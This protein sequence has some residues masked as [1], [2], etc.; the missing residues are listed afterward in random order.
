[1]ASYLPGNGSGYGV[2]GNGGYG[3][4]GGRERGARRKRLAAVAGRVYS[5]GAS[6][7]SE[8][9]ESYNQTRS[10]QIDTPESIKMTIPGSF[11]D[12]AIVTRGNEQMVLF[13]SYAKRHVKNSQRQYANPGGPPHPASMDMNEQEYWSQEW[14]RHEDE[15]AIVDV[16][17]RGWIY[18]PHK[19]P[20]TRRNRV[21]I[22]LARQLSGIP[23]PRA[24]QQDPEPSLG[25]IHRQHEEEREHMRITK[26]AKEIERR[27]QAEKEAAQVGG[28]SEAPKQ[29][30]SEEEGDDR[31]LYP[32]SG[33]VTSTL[34]SAPGSPTP[35]IGR[36]STV[37]GELSDAELAVA[38]ANLMARLGPFLTTPLV[39][40]SV[41]FFFYNDTQSQSRT[42]ETNDS[43]HFIMRAALDFVPTHV[44]VLANEDLSVTEPVQIIEPK[45]VSLISDIDDTIKHSN[46]S[47]GAKEIFRNTF[48]R[49]L[50][51]L[52]VDGVQE[53]PW[54]LFPVIASY[55]KLAG[56]PPGSIHLK[57]YSGMLQG[58]FEPVAERKKGTL[59]KIMMDFPDRKFLLVGD[60]GEADLEVYTEIAVSNPGRIIAIFI[61]DVT[62]PEQ[63]GYF[64][65][66]F[67][68]GNGRNKGKAPSV[69]IDQRSRGGSGD[70][71]SSRSA[72]PARML[73]EPPEADNTA[74]GDLINL[75]EEPE[76]ISP[77]DPRALSASNHNQPIRKPPPPRPAKP[78][79]LKS[80]PAIPTGKSLESGN[81]TD[82]K[83]PPPPPQPRKPLV[84][85]GQA[86]RASA[87]HPLAQTHTLSRE[88]T[89]DV[90]QQSFDQPR[91]ND[92]R[93]S[94]TSSSSNSFS[95]KTHA[96][97]PP[98][99][100]R[101][102]T[103]SSSRS[104][105]PRLAAAKQRST[106]NSEVD[107]EPLPPTSSKSQNTTWNSNTASGRNSP[108]QA[109]VNKKLDLWRLRLER[110][111]DT[112]DKEGVALYTWR[113]G[114]DVVAEAVGIVKSA[115]R[116]MGIKGQEKK[117]WREKLTR[118][119]VQL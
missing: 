117:D 39:E 16:D 81:T 119:K 28:Y 95:S 4:D 49:D 12:V 74:T 107:W 44:R 71:G 113:R 14:A 77:G 97:P 69:R 10:G 11:P 30:D 78:I 47:L 75:S 94:I 45:G 106:A 89:F 102:G 36:T 55:F 105:S 17:V 111:Q 72:M 68:T 8:I 24:Q 33:S 60:S 88:S 110:A 62:T 3:S 31:F 23:A 40:R 82:L 87:S 21:L 56:L 92:Q 98:P 118:E 58:I 13:P 91:N 64:D 46:I 5:A 70:D 51:D 93:S 86:A 29:L 41:T 50:S 26:K 84:S 79:S 96:P 66:A 52:T 6:A 103:P 2:G 22:G 20:M 100:R 108:N 116:D 25:A 99:P 85:S 15:K 32:R 18:N 35:S 115:M 38:N 112:L 61:R 76:T 48:I 1:M 57:K 34:A 90:S 42:I 27:G 65:S 109:P 43:G 37:S 73:T 101:R 104:L 9:K 7:M 83:K 19:G 80:S 53:C 63:T 114:D 59:E 67:D 54:Q